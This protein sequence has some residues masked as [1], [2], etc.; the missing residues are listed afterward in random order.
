GNA[1][2]VSGYELPPAVAPHKNVCKAGATR[3]YLPCL[4]LD[5]HRHATGYHGSL[6]VDPYVRIVNVVCAFSLA[7][8][9]FACHVLF[10]IGYASGGVGKDKIFP[11]DAVKVPVI[12]IEVGAPDL[13]LNLYQVVL[14]LRR[15]AGRSILGITAYVAEKRQDSYEKYRLHGSSRGI[16]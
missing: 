2:R 10:L 13:A 4:V 3:H 15:P 9:F 12:A 8:I 11:L 16:R 1:G 6:A 7:A 5:R 14:D